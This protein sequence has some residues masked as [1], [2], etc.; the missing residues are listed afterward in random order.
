MPNFNPHIRRGHSNMPGDLEIEYCQ[1][2]NALEAFGWMETYVVRLLNIHCLLT[3]DVTVF[4]RHLRSSLLYSEE[5]LQ[6]VAVTVFVA[7]LYMCEQYLHCGLLHE[8][9]EVPI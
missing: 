4:S 7:S 5:F 3:H 2:L 1:E 8:V 6:V 9:P